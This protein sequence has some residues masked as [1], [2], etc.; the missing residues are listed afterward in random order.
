MAQTRASLRKQHQSASKARR[1]GKD[2]E[3]APCGTQDFEALSHVLGEEDNESQAVTDNA[4][5]EED[6][7]DLVGMTEDM[8]D[9]SIRQVLQRTKVALMENFVDFSLLDSDENPAK[10][11]GDTGVALVEEESED[12][13][14]VEDILQ[15]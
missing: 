5:L 2:K 8:L 13:W 9:M 7:E 1:A 14:D 11:N 3:H 12:N 15:I 10:D 6:G 4:L